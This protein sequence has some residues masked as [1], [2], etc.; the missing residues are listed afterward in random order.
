M[1]SENVPVPTQCGFL[2]VKNAT[3]QIF[4]S[5]S[6]CLRFLCHFDGGMGEF[7]V[8]DGF[9]SEIYP[10]PLFSTPQQRGWR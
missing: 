9:G 4:F 2:P 6:F 1:F 7:K 5:I 10:Q 8:E 3:T